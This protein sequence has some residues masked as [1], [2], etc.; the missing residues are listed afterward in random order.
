MVMIIYDIAILRPRRRAER[1]L[2]EAGFVFLFGNVRWTR[3]PVDKCALVRRLRS[4]LRG[5]A[6][7][8]VVLDVPGRSIETARWL[9]RSVAK[10]SK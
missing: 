1:L 9:H 10:V 5:E 8:I 7:R 6:F 3:L 2:R 4:T